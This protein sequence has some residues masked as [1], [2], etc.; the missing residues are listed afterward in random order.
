MK[1]MIF[2]GVS[3]GENLVNFINNASSSVKTVLSK[4]GCF[5]RNTNH[6]RFLQKQL[7]QTVQQ[8]GDSTTP[9]VRLSTPSNVSAAKNNINL[10]NS[11]E[12]VKP[13]PSIERVCAAT[14]VTSTN[15]S[16]YPKKPTIT[17][18]I[19]QRTIRKKRRFNPISVKPSLE[20]TTL[21]A[22]TS[23]TTTPPPNILSS[24]VIPSPTSDYPEHY[25]YDIPHL[26][27]DYQTIQRDFYSDRLPSPDYS[28]TP[29]YHSAHLTSI[30]PGTGHFY[31][32]NTTT[33]A[34][35]YVK[36]EEDFGFCDF[37]SG[38]DLMKSLE[39]GDLFIPDCTDELQQKE[40]IYRSF[41]ETEKSLKY[42]A[43]LEALEASC[44]AREND[45]LNQQ[46]AN[47]LWNFPLIHSRKKKLFF[48]VH[49]IVVVFYFYYYLNF[50]YFL[51]HYNFISC[52]WYL[53]NHQIKLD[54][55]FSLL[56]KK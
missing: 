1:N 31:R 27:A 9:T 54:F 36:S 48:S 12:D 23:T 42:L 2:T 46:L 10:N 53:L 26:T 17:K 43:Q 33:Y 24:V 22:T 34:S 37:L 15:Y 29:S 41:L 49:I 55:S 30:Y 11:N 28:S 5:K 32:S 56:M 35:S 14:T 45:L 3:S 6:R 50:I 40:F 39:F 13:S 21:T 8:Q 38:E 47:S 18:S 7:R 20:T 4:P 51:H 25:E 44:Y 19:K 16:S 52:S